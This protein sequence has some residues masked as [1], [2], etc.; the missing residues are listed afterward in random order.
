MHYCLFDFACIVT[1]TLCYF[2]RFFSRDPGIELRFFSV[3]LLRKNREIKNTSKNVTL[4]LVATKHSLSRA[5]C[6]EL[7]IQNYMPHTI[8]ACMTT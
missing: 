4:N 5:G 8:S 1:C 3:S 2:S 6:M 7:C